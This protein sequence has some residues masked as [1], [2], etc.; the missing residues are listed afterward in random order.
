[1]EVEEN[2]P[3][4]GGEGVDDPQPASITEVL[5]DEELATLPENIRGKLDGWTAEIARNVKSVVTEKDSQISRLSAANE[6]LVSRNDVLKNEVAEARKNLDETGD[7]YRAAVT[8]LARVEETIIGYQKQISESQ[9]NAN[10]AIREKDELVMVVDKRNEEVERLTES[11]KSLS[12]QLQAA[13]VAK[14]EALCKIDELTGKDMELEYKGKELEREKEWVG[15]QVQMLNDELE[16]KNSEIIATQREFSIKHLHL[17]TELSEKNEQIKISELQLANCQKANEAQEKHIEH[18]ITKLKDSEDIETK[19]Q[20]NYRQ[21][22]SAQRKI[23]DLYK[24]SSEEASKKVEELEDAVSSL[25]DLLKNATSKYGELET[26]FAKVGKSFQDEIAEKHEQIAKI[27]K[28]LENANKLIESFQS[29]GLTNE[30]IQSLSPAA[31]AATNMLKNSKSLTQIYSEYH[32]LCDEVIIKKQ[33][34]NKLNQ[35]VKELLQEIETQG[36]ELEREKLKNQTNLEKLEIMQNQLDLAL[37]DSEKSKAETSHANRSLGAMERENNRLRSQLNDLAM[38]VRSLLKETEV[39][40]GNYSAVASRSV[41]SGV[42]EVPDI[43]TSAQQVVS[44]RLVTFRNIEELQMQNQ[45]LLAVVREL[46][47]SQEKATREAHETQLQLIKDSFQEAMRELEVLREKRMTQDKLLQSAI[48]QR[49]ALAELMKQPKSPIKVPDPSAAGK[50]AEIQ[51]QYEALQAA[52]KSVQEEFDTYKKERAEHEKIAVEQVEK[53]RD[54]VMKMRTDNAKLGSQVEYN[55][56]RA[57]IY[58]ANLETYKKNINVLEERNKKYS[59][60][61]LKLEQS[62]E[63][64]KS[65][66]SGAQNKLARTEVALNSMTQER[67][68]LRDTNARLQAER[69]ILKR[70]QNTQQMLRLNLQEIK[71]GLNMSN[72]ALKTKMENEIETLRRDNTILQR[73]VSTETER[74]KEAVF[75]WE[76]ANKELIH[77]LR[78]DQDSLQVTK[79][80]LENSKATIARLNGEIED[81]QSQVKVLSNTTLD[82]VNASEDQPV[83]IPA[84]E[85]QIKDLKTQLRDAKIENETMTQHLAVSRQSAE[86]YRTLCG[87]IEGQISIVSDTSKQLTEELQQRLEGKDEIIRDIQ[88]RLSTSERETASLKDEKDTIVRD[89]EAKSI[90]LEEEICRMRRDLQAANTKLQTAFEENVQV[91][92][93]LQKQTLVYQDIQE[94]YEKELASHS[95]DVN[96]LN[97]MKNELEAVRLKIIDEEQAR[98]NAENQL[99]QALNDW[100]SK[101]NAMKAEMSNLQENKDELEKLNNSLQDQI[102]NLTTRLEAASKPA[103]ESGDDASGSVEAEGQ[104]KSS[105]EWLQLIRYMRREK[106]IAKTK[107]EMAEATSSRY[108]N[109]IIHLQKQIED[110]KRELS[111]LQ[112]TSHVSIITSAKQADLLRKVET[113]SALTDSNRMLREEKDAAVKELEELKQKVAVLDVEIGPLREKSSELE[114]RCEALLNENTAL[115]QDI[116][117]WRTRAASLLEKSNKV[118]PEEMKRLQTETDNLTK[119]V[120]A[121]QEV[122]RKQQLEITR[123]LLQVKQ[124]QQQ[125][126]ALQ[127]TNQALQNEKK[128]LTDEHKKVADEKEKL[129]AEAQ[130]LRLEV[131]SLKNSQVAKDENIERANKEIENVNKLLEEQKNTVK[132]VKSIARKYKKQYEDLLKEQEGFPKQGQQEGS[133][134]ENVNIGDSSTVTE[135]QREEIAKYEAQV[136]QL[137]EEIETMKRESDTVKTDRGTADERMRAVIKTLREKLSVATA[138]KADVESKLNEYEAKNISMKNREEENN[139]RFAA[140]KSQYEGRLVRLEKENK[141]LKATATGNAPEFAALQQ[142]NDDLKKEQ[143]MMKQRVAALENRFKLQSQTSKVASPE[144]V[145]PVEKAKANIRPIAGPSPKQAAVARP[146]LTASIRPIS[147]PRKATVSVS[148]M[149]TQNSQA[150]SSNIQSVSP[151]VA[152]VSQ[153]QVSTSTPD[154]SSSAP[155]SSPQ[156]QMHQS[157]AVNA[158]NV[159]ISSAG[160]QAAAVQPTVTVAPVAVGLGVVGSNNSVSTPASGVSGIGG[161][162][163]QQGSSGSSSGAANDTQAAHQDPSTSSATQIMEESEMGDS[164]EQVSSSEGST[165]Q[166]ILSV[167]PLRSKQHDAQQSSSSSSSIQHQPQPGPS[168]KKQTSTFSEEPSPSSSTLR[169]TQSTNKRSRED[170]HHS[171]HDDEEDLLNEPDTKRTRVMGSIVDREAEALGQQESSNDQ[172]IEE[173]EEEEDEQEADQGSSAADDAQVQLSDTTTKESNV[174]PSGRGNDGHDSDSDVII[175]DSEDDDGEVGRTSSKASTSRV[176]KQLPVEEEEADDV[177]EEDEEVGDEEEQDDEEDLMEEEDDVDEDDEDHGDDDDGQEGKKM[178][179]EDYDDVEDQEGREAESLEH[180]DNEIQ[181]VDN[182][183]DDDQ[184]ILDSNDSNLNPMDFSSQDQ[185]NQQ[186]ELREA[187]QSIDDEGLEDGELV[188]EPIVSAP[189]AGTS[190]SLTASGSPIR[191]PREFNTRPQSISTPMRVTPAGRGSLPPQ[192]G[193]QQPQLTPSFSSGQYADDADDSIVPSTPTLFVPRRSDGFAEAVSSPQIQPGGR[194]TFSS[195]AVSATESSSSGAHAGTSASSSGN[196][197]DDTRLDFLGYDEGGGSGTTGRSVPSTPLQV[198]PPVEGLELAAEMAADDDAAQEEALSAAIIVDVHPTSSSIASISG[199]DVPAITVTSAMESSS[200]M[201]FQP[202]QE[203][204]SKGTLDPA[205]LAAMGSQQRTSTQSEVSNVT[206]SDEDKVLV[207]GTSSSSNTGSMQRPSTSSRAASPTPSSNTS[208]PPTEQK[209]PLPQ[210][211]HHHH[212]HQQQQ[213]GRTRPTPI[214]WDQ[215]SSSSSANPTSR[216][217]RGGMMGGRGGGTMAVRHMIQPDQGHIMPPMLRG[218]YRPMMMMRGQNQSARR[219]RPH[220]RGGPSGGVGPGNPGPGPGSVGG[221]MPFQKPY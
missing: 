207:A 29:K 113:L 61:T 129:R 137:Q 104:Q 71:N 128:I 55:N 83:T 188:P 146:P 148:A 168:T 167:A 38:Q 89:F 15:K 156:Q 96:T 107:T 201:S 40:R 67:N 130:T 94:K 214:V 208:N 19:M 25:Q 22:L 42:A 48:H 133:S 102:I 193:R 183:H 68:S 163:Q 90:A 145:L 63:M 199:S 8:N 209:E 141:E 114:G 20:E 101:G 64:L 194:F 203:G 26:K 99:N 179:E 136:K 85:R 186:H 93:D 32:D 206:S 34:I 215:P 191:P 117:R 185:S 18:L 58:N 134:A 91:K 112:D 195:V 79:E 45:R 160:R 92:S 75:S 135:A 69:D 110:L 49:D 218:G 2:V 126:L 155:E 177:D 154:Q 181:E 138:E 152:P 54:D 39:Q 109:Q 142:E 120:Q 147:M 80:E 84:L 213:G 205:R 103:G 28:E 173:E 51:R 211:Q 30:M 1:M 197:L 11:M 59:A 174:R 78:N 100:T 73:K 189:V 88:A 72:S 33:E 118:N 97:E 115:K 217:A 17:Q 198:S 50:L 53:L 5:T 14:I 95:A 77:R 220:S 56:E 35:M 41:T 46:T 116:G 178:D 36:P 171:H 157:L 16:K 182:S 44:D 172:M 164:S 196:V 180:D 175:I 190:S 144:K 82:T 150:S 221:R 123:N 140:L 153:A 43:E 60:T 98:R 21:E 159:P 158:S 52:H 139:V 65:E 108:E 47:E 37:R 111:E 212:H 81:L 119:Q 143:E 31:A 105:E 57:K 62:I 87:S 121:V 219:S 210:P 9:I 165:H 161:P 184:D 70:D 7:R 124:L 204:T 170:P 131:S 166:N 149:P 151:V 6:E 24:E 27:Q 162:Q 132:A 216:P 3:P 192:L 200:R 23:A 202:P 4:P 86:E 106:E 74:F 127:S 12:D 125:T 169:P 66:L 187:E 122:N 13:T 76:S 176:M 10:V